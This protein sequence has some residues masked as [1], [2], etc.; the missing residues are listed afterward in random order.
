MCLC[1]KIN[2]IYSADG[3]YHGRPMQMTKVAPTQSQVMVKKTPNMVTKYG[4]Y[5]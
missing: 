2:K 5:R 1:N 4:N 3:R